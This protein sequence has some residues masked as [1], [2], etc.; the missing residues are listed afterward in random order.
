MSVYVV[1]QIDVTD[2]VAYETYKGLAS[3]S[4]GLYDGRY[5]VRGGTTTTLEGNW[6][7]GRFVLLEFPTAERAKAWHDSPEYGEARAAR[8]DAANV[9][10]ILVEGPSYDPRVAAATSST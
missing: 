8:R 6:D 10:M 1:V 7:P 9:K 3:P 2:P 5:A 4:I